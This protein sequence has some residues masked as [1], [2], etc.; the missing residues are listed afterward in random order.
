MIFDD[1]P[2]ELAVAIAR[3][4]E[5]LGPFVNLRY[6]AELDSTNDTALALAQ[7]GAGEG[8][9]VLAD[10]QRAGRGRRGRTWFSPGG[11]GIY[12]SALVMPP[13]AEVPPGFITLAA[14]VSVAEAVRRVSGLPVLLKWPN[15]IVIG[16]HW[17][18]IGGVLCE[19]ATAGAPVEVVVVGIGLNLSETVYPAEI[20]DRAT[21]LEAELGRGV[22]VS[23]LVVELLAQLKEC[24][25]WL[26]GGATDRIRR[27][28]LALGAEGWI[29]ARVAWHD[30]NTLRRGC[31]RGID[32]DGALIVDVEG[33]AERI[34]AGEVH[35]E[36]QARG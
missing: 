6:A 13:S 11:A 7:R 18:K 36:T 20:R 30:G 22:A 19:T 23:A 4:S 27:A 35:W 15:D 26:R 24:M 10:Y 3:A 16:R 25:A 28:W 9:S 12:L 31:V 33:A 29:G 32:G 17:R 8:V 34:M 1:V 21:S 14:G 2:V 5:R